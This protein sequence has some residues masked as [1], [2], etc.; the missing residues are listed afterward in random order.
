MKY[1]VDHEEGQSGHDVLVNANTIVLGDTT[2]SIEPTDTPDV[3]TLTLN[4]ISTPMLVQSDGVSS[5]TVHVRG[6]SISTTVLPEQHHTAMSILAASPALKNRSVKIA[7]PMPGLLRSVLVAEGAHVKKGDTL[8]T[9][10]A[11]KMENMIKAPISGIVRSLSTQA[12]V[13]VEKG[14]PLCTIESSEA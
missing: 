14:T 8:F 11:M 3:Y 6:Q 12:N 9:L 2:Y 13:A 7:A 4:G 10:E 1:H 5:V